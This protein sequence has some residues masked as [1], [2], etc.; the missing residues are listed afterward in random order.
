MSAAVLEA[1]RQY[2]R[3]GK[4]D[5]FLAAVGG[6]RGLFELA[7]SDPTLDVVPRA[8]DRYLRTPQGRK[9]LA[10]EPILLLL[11]G[12]MAQGQPEALRVLAI[13]QL[14]YLTSPRSE[15]KLTSS[16]AAAE[17]AGGDD[18]AALAAFLSSPVFLEVVKCVRAESLSVATAVCGLLTALTRL[19]KGREAFFAEAAQ[20]ALIG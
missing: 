11:G 4:V 5:P 1:I 13:K 9:D 20:Q 6:L 18:D 14:E 19:P 10:S 2:L 7:I 16:T 15:T 17:A 3:D 12:A 8:I